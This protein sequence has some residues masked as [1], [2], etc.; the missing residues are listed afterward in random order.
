MLVATNAVK[1]A[2]CE[3]ECQYISS[4]KAKSMVITS[5]LL[6]PTMSII[7]RS[8]IV[9]LMSVVLYLYVMKKWH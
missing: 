4:E 1:A 3:A 9:K 2:A 7:L 5:I 8:Y 6:S